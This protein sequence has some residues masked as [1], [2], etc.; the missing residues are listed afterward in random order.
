MKKTV[1]FVIV[2]VCIGLMYLFP[3]STI[4]P[5]ELVEAHQNINQKCLSCHIPFKGISNEKCITCHKLSDIG[6]DTSKSVI[7]SIDEQVLFHKNLSNQECSSCHT[8][9]KG[10]IPQNSISSF[11]HDLLSESVISNC[12]S[13]HNKPIDPLHNL[14]SST[15][16]D[17]HN[18][19]DWKSDVNFDHNKISGPGKNMCASCHKSPAD[20]FHASIK[21]NCD[22][23]HSTSQW[24]PSTFD[25]SEYFILDKNHNAECNTCHAKNNFKAYTCYGCHEHSE[26]KIIEEHREEDIS[27]ISDCVSCHRSGDE[28]DIRMNGRSEQRIDKNEYKKVRDV[29]RP[30]NKE[31]KKS[32]SGKKDDDND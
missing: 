4:S 26:N 23:C 14:L 22:K 30:D 24:K 7:G 13:C 8:D 9:H 31:N 5:G 12:N 21:D 19:T 25:H 27:N 15:C 11:K 32:G 10:R 20:E 3:H 1:A 2:I 28:H 29:I 6:R 18:T 16:K 17:C